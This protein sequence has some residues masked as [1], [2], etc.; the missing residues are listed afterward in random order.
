MAVASSEIGF[1]PVYNRCGESVA[2]KLSEL[3]AMN[4]LV[5]CF[6]E[7]QVDNVDCFPFIEPLSN[8]FFSR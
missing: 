4:Y 7:I 8:C 5:K 6:G 1:E 3:K 2:F